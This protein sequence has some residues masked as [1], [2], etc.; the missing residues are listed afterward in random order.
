MNGSLIMSGVTSAPPKRRAP[1]L[2][3]EAGQPQDVE[4]DRRVVGEVARIGAVEGARS[5]RRQFPRPLGQQGEVGLVPGLGQDDDGDEQSDQETASEKEQ[6][7]PERRPML[8]RAAGS[9]HTHQS[10]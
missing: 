5:V 3:G 6:Q 9:D 4:V 2:T 10:K 8:V 1:R 7:R